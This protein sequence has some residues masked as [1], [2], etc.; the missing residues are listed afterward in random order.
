MSCALVGG[1]WGRVLFGAMLLVL[2]AS[3]ARAD[4]VCASPSEPSLAEL[5][6]RALRTAAL[7]PERMRSLL[8]RVRVAALLP[9]VQVHVGRGTLDYARNPDTLEPT[10]TSTDSW[11]FDV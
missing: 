3:G 5:S 9:H 10:F 4:G 1:S 8:R 6:S 7:E 11:R 2:L